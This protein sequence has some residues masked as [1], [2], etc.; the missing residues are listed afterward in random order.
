MALLVSSNMSPKAVIGRTVQRP[1]EAVLYP[2]FSLER[3]IHFWPS[4]SKLKTSISSFRQPSSMW[5]LSTIKECFIVLIYLVIGFKPEKIPKGGLTLVL[6][7][8]GNV[9]VHRSCQHKAHRSHAKTG[10]SSPSNSTPTLAA[11]NAPRKKAIWLEITRELSQ[12]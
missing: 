12:G 4:P 2:S 1:H 8:C 7:N 3:P 5:T 9:E 10:T 6:M 11:Y